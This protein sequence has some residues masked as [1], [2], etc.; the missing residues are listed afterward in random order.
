M[1]K[2]IASHIKWML[3][4]IDSWIVG[5]I[6][7]QEQAGLLRAKYPAP[8]EKDRGMLILTAGGA[9]IFGLGVILILA[10]N[11]DDLSRY[12]KMVLIFSGIAAA[13][14]AGIRFSRDEERKGM[15]EGFHVLGTMFFGAAVWLIAQAYNINDHYPNGML[16]W[17]VGAWVL[18]WAIPSMAQCII[19]LII[20]TFWSGFEALDFRNVQHAAPFLIILCA[21]PLAFTKRSMVLAA[22]MTAAFMTSMLFTFLGLDDRITVPLFM[23]LSGTVIMAG[24]L[25]KMQGVFTESSYLLTAAGTLPFL[26]LAYSLSFKESAYILVRM[27]IEGRG[28]LYFIFLASASIIFTAA[29]LAVNYKRTKKIGPLLAVQA[30]AIAASL[31]VFIYKYFEAA[32]AE[33]FRLKVSAAAKG[34]QAVPE[35]ELFDGWS[36]ALIFNLILLAWA[37]TTVWEG[38]GSLNVKKISAGVILFALLAFTRYVDLFDNLI[39]RGLVF[40]AVGGAIFAVGAFYNRI[41]KEGGS[42]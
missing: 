40:L 32:R 41:K 9:V 1:S 12:T 7:T 19:A 21:A 16:A 6:I 33:I 37:F 14:A 17:A 15:S 24:R 27:G 29:A 2:K 3:E 4:E 5:G 18:A 10:Y 39:T 26:G 20:L 28:G 8:V 42:L 25:I 23:L 30:A 31:S 34:T 11:W 13:H 38:I 22:L 35:M 36:L